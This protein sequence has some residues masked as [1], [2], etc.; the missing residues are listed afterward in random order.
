MVRGRLLLLGGGGGRSG[1]AGGGGAGGDV[2]RGLELAV[3]QEEVICMVEGRCKWQ[4]YSG[5]CL[6]VA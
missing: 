2:R 1:H 4:T 3:G 6:G 5:C